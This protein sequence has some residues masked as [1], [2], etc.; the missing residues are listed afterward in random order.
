MLILDCSG[1]ALAGSKEEAGEIIT[2]YAKEVNG[3]PEAGVFASGF[4]T[5]AADAALANGT[6]AH[7][8]DYDDYV[9]PN[10]TGHPTAPIL[11]AIFALGQRQKSRAKISC[12][13]MSWASRPARGSGPVWPGALR[14]RLAPH[15]YLRYDGCHGG[16]LQHIEIECGADAVGVRHCQ[17]RSE[18]CETELRHHDQ[19]ASCRSIGAKRR[20]GRSAGRK[21]VH[22][23]RERN[24]GALWFRQGVF[25]RGRIMIRPRSVRAWASP[26]F[27]SNTA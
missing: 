24:R 9:L 6:M 11:P 21:G 23:R 16:M 26:I 1:V 25:R 8:L 12:W 18:R 3:R 15:G 13:P 17:L 14:K 5:S 2:S 22:R 7:A 19:A 20:D 4:K 27:S 10:W